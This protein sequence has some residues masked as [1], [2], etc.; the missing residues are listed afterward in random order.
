MTTKGLPEVFGSSEIHGQIVQQLLMLR[1]LA[2]PC[3]VARCSTDKDDQ[4]RWSRKGCQCSPDIELVSS[5]RGW[6]R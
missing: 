4:I 2:R 5:N 6:G 3:K 1:L